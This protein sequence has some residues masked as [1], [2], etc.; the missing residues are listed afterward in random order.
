MLRQNLAK[1]STVVTG[2]KEK[3]YDF[4]QL[5][6]EKKSKVLMKNTI[7]IKKIISNIVTPRKKETPELKKPQAQA[8]KISQIAVTNVVQNSLP[9]NNINNNNLNKVSH[10]PKSSANYH[11]IKSPSVFNINL[12]LNLN[13][14]LNV[15]TTTST[16]SKGFSSKNFSKKLNENTINPKKIIDRQADEVIPNPALKIQTADSKKSDG[17]KFAF[18]D[19][20][21]RES[22]TKKPSITSQQGQKMIEIK[23][24]YKTNPNKPLSNNFQI[25][26]VGSMN[27]SDKN[28]LIFK[29]SNPINLKIDLNAKLKAEDK[30][31]KTTHVKTE[32]YSLE[33]SARMAFKGIKINNFDKIYQL[34]DSPK[35]Q[36]NSTNRESKEK[37]KKL[38]FK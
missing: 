34:K 25:P 19:R 22:L 5:N 1:E 32:S 20:G 12:N 35:K 8:G 9:M 6:L 13:L 26:K 37:V 3:N 15:N 30:Q 10:A 38:L 11:S 36:P 17:K 23:A 16:N 4:K 14:N 21:K 7:S 2:N 18:T 31:E 33:G 24:Q 28:K 29:K 27:N